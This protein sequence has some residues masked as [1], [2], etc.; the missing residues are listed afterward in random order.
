MVAVRGSVL[1]ISS[2]RHRVGG[3]PGADFL[4]IYNGPFYNNTRI[5]ANNYHQQVVDGVLTGSGVRDP[6]LPAA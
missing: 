3:V 2:G 1:Q 6:L 4:T 5:L